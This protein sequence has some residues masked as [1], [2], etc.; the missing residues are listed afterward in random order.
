MKINLKRL[1]F[2]SPVNAALGF[3]VVIFSH[4]VLATTVVDSQI[5]FTHGTLREFHL[6]GQE[7]LVILVMIL[8]VAFVYLGILI[9]LFRE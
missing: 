9:D 5:R 4:E 7:L 8:P 1:I 2:L 6:G 3:S